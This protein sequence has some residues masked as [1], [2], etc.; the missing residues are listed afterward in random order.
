MWVEA[1][2]NSYSSSL[3]ITL[4]IPYYGQDNVYE[5]IGFLVH[6]R[7]EKVYNVT[8]TMSGYSNIIIMLV[9]M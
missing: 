2:C 7:Q 9:E 6:V 5:I 3:H 4:R 8:L 1:I